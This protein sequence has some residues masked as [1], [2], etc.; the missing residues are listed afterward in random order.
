MAYSPVQLKRPLIATKKI[1][2]RQVGQALVAHLSKI[3]GTALIK[4]IIIN[5]RTLNLDYPVLYMQTLCMVCRPSR[6]CMVCRP[7]LENNQ[8]G[9]D[10]GF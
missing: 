9:F 6:V 3:T 5:L 8:H 2:F 1:H 10:L 7:S 4:F